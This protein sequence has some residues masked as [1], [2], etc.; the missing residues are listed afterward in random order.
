MTCL[1]RTLLALAIGLACA[2]AAAAGERANTPALSQ[3]DAA[4]RAAR[5]A[6]VDYVLDFALSGKE[7]FS[8]TSTIAFDLKDAG[9]ALT[10]DLNE[11]TITALTVNGKT[12][13]PKYNGWFITIAPDALRSGRNTV[14]VSYERKHGRNGEGLHRMVDPIDGRVYVYSQFGPAAAQQAFASFDQP[15]LKASYQ[16]NVTAPADW[17]V[18]STAPEAGIETVE[19]GRRWHFQKTQKLSTYTVSLHAG[20]Y[21]KWEDRSGKYPMRLYARQSVAGKVAPQ[22]WFKYTRQ[23]LAWFDKYYGIAYPFQK[24]DQLLV[25]DHLFGAM[26]NTAAVTFAEANYLGD[27]AMSAEKRQALAGVILHE[28]AHQWFGDMVTMKWWNGV[29]LNE[30]FA[31]F[32]GTLATDEGTEFINAWQRFYA[33]SKARAYQQDT[34]TMP[35]AVDTPVASS[36][37]AYDN[38]DAITYDKGASTLVQLRHLLGDEVFRKGVHNYLEKF[39]WKNATLEDFVATLGEASGRDLKPRAA[40]WLR[41]PGVNTIAANYACSGGRVSRF[42]LQQGA[43]N[44]ILREQRVQ[45]AFLRMQGK[46]LALDRAIAVNYKGASTPVPGLLGSPCPE[47]VYPNY[48]DWGYVKVNLDARSFATAA[49][50]LQ[51]VAD[52]FMRAMLWDSLWDGVRDGKQGLL[53]FLGSVSN[54]APAER[55]PAL[56]AEV[57]RKARLG[58]D[59]LERMPARGADARKSGEALEQMAIKAFHGRAGESALQRQWFDFYLAVASSNE[60]LGR[61]RSMLGGPP[62]MFGIE[63]SQEVRWKIV[64]TLNE[65][66]FPGSLELLEAEA[67][68]DPGDSGKAAAVLALA[69]RPDA[70]VKAAWLADVLDPHSDKPVARLRAAMTALYPPSQGALAEQTAALRLERLAE[71]E[72]STGG[73]RLR[74][75]LSTMLP[76]GCT[77]RSVQRLAD[78]LAQGAALA[79]GTR[80]ALMV[81]RQEDA[82]CVAMERAMGVVAP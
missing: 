65:Y 26:E 8:G 77:A 20:P 30:S 13:A 21:R 29:W 54:N 27:G 45:V 17:E 41:E 1:A 34:Q 40:Q 39:A 48:K 78:A 43:D 72:K 64:R 75:Y 63:I 81:A 4:E 22:E 24:Y 51:D 10:V 59:Y 49:A 3:Q 32:M 14:A 55:D 60:A 56:L 36:A 71:L 15:D 66:G 5:V 74:T 6:N 70:K 19:G 25:P 7:A 58:F 50:H 62:D 33:G 76:M 16:F 9:Q 67:A 23:G 52:P 46:A 79:P 18:V 28:M 37:G 12:I 69:G 2:G 42:E 44:G 31:S 38:L 11:A 73:A 61:L 35:H 68:R 82:R 47:L 57:L 80:R 53:A